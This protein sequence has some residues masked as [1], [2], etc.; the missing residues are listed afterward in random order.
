MK[1]YLY[2]ENHDK[3]TTTSNNQRIFG[4]IY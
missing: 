3:S 4:R 2:G 1:I